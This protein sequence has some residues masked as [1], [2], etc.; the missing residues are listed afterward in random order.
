MR[1]HSPEWQSGKSMSTP[2]FSFLRNGRGLTL[3]IA[4]EEPTRLMI[5][6][7]DATILFLMSVRC[8][9]KET[10][11]CLEVKK[12]TGGLLCLAW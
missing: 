2:P 3:P 11:C 5:D 12:L 4:H 1:Y 7:P 10:K 6:L 9:T 8:E